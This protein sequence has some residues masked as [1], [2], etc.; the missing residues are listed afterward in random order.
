MATPEQKASAGLA[1]L[2]KLQLTQAPLA[3]K[4]SKDW[5]AAKLTYS[6]TVR[7]DV[8]KVTDP[9]TRAALNAWFSDPAA[10]AAYTKAVGGAVGSA[11]QGTGNAIGSGASVVGGLPTDVGN[12]VGQGLANSFQGSIMGFLGALTSPNTW[13]RIGEAVL[14]IALVLVGAAK[15]LGPGVMNVVPAGRLA[16]A[17]TK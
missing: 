7:A 10:V 16:K 5:S 1:A 15:L 6:A 3:T 4:I 9:A 14:G 12:A 13:L 8:A 11:I 17:V 2:Q